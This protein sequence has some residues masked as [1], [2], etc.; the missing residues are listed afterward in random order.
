[1]DTINCIQRAIDYMEDNLCGELTIEAISGR[2]LMSGYHFQHLFSIV[3][4]ISLGEYIRSRRLALAGIEI[5]HSFSRDGAQSQGAAPAVCQNI[6]P[7]YFR[8]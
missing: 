6:C 4:N 1:M 7:V 3:C 8:R 5:A 2:A